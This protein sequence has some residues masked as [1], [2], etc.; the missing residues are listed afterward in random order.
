MTGAQ[1]PPRVPPGWEHASGTDVRL[2]DAAGGA[3]AWIAPE[4]GA[5][6]FAFAV[7]HAA[8]WTNILHTTDAAEL[9]ALPSRFGIPILFPFPGHMMDFHYQWRGTTYHIPRHGSTRPSF[10]HGFAHNRPWRVIAQSDDAVTTEFATPDDLT[11][12]ERAGYPFAVRLQ[13]AMRVTNGGLEITL[14]A[15]N[16][17]SENAPVGL[18]LHPYFAAAALGGDRTQIAVRLPGQ[19]ERLTATN[20]PTGETRPATDAPIPVPPLGETTL[21]VRTDLGAHPVA[22]LTGGGNRV[23]FAFTEG[24]RDLV[25]FAPDAQPSL[26][27]EPHTLAPGAASQT[28]GR[29]DG[30]HPLA[31]G[32]SL[33]LSVRLSLE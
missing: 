20:V 22:T 32:A 16:E 21:V 24:V 23:V 26:S 29:P 31:P 19:T 6:C 14:R 8:G 17:G 33:V 12:D 7:R 4:R 1:E 27:I 28:E 25:F 11:N 15:T 18:G 10:T 9:A 30:L 2:V 13:S 5:N 3:V